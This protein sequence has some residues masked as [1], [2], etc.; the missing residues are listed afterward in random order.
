M[1]KFKTC[2][3]VIVGLVLLAPVGAVATIHTDADNGLHARYSLCR[4]EPQHWL[5]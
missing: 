1:E 4:H 3:I 2:L 5:Q